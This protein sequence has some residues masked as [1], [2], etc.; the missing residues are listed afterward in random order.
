MYQFCVLSEY[1]LYV[2]VASAALHDDRLA[3]VYVALEGIVGHAGPAGPSRAVVHILVVAAVPEATED[4]QGTGRADG[5]RRTVE[6][7]RTVAP[8]RRIPH[9]GKRQIGPGSARPPG[10]PILA[11]HTEAEDVDEV[12][13]ADDGHVAHDNAADAVP[14]RLPPDTRREVLMPDGGVGSDPEDVHC[15][16]ALGDRYGCAQEDAVKGS[17]VRV[18]RATRVTLVVI[19]IVRPSREDVQRVGIRSKGLV[20]RRHSCGLFQGPDGAGVGQVVGHQLHRAKGE[21]RD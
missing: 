7:L 17:P 18:P 5:G 11:V 4:L 20:R 10:V 13:R 1:L 6:P 8:S 19:I 2:D 12:R 21:G 16:V 3:A 14:A 15:A 9:R